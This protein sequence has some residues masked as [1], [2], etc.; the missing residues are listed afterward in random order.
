MKFKTAHER[1]VFRLEEAQEGMVEF[2]Q[3]IQKDAFSAFDF[4]SAYVAAA[5]TIRVFTIVV[6]RLKDIDAKKLS[7]KE[8]VEQMIRYSTDRVMS[9]ASRGAVKSTSVLAAELHAEELRA[10]HEIVNI[11]NGV[12]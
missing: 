8:V 10:W 4:A 3:K 5:A 7:E 6:N 11:L 12:E 1:L 9:L 2:A